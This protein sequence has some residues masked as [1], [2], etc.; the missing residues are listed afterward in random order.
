MRKTQPV[1]NILYSTLAGAFSLVLITGCSEQNFG[2]TPTTKDFAQSVKYNRQADVL[3][4]ME[5]SGAMDQQQR[6]KAVSDQV[7]AMM[8]VLNAANL[9]YH[10]AVTT[11]TPRF[12]DP[13]TQTMVGDGGRFITHGDSSPLVLS[14][15]LS[16]L[17][18]VLTN[19]LNF[20]SG[21]FISPINFG[22]L[23]VQ[24][25]LSA[26]LLDGFNAGFLR[27]DAL[28]N[29]IFI[30]SKD[31][32]VNNT[33]PIDLGGFLDKLR[34]PVAATGQ[35][36]WLAHYVGVLS[37]SP[38]DQC[39]S[40][41]WNY[42]SPGIKFLDIV[43]ASGGSSS[44]ICSTDLTLAVQQVQARILEI[45][46]AYHLNDKPNVSTIVVYAAGV[47]VPQ[48]AKNGWTYDDKI[49]SIV[50]HGLAIPPDGT[51]FHVDYTPAGIK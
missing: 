31:D 14:S 37:S 9:D 46:T 47:L 24:N 32:D 4:V 2:L 3:I 44:T 6:Y 20:N 21:D 40:G 42:K 50:F 41:Q 1:K 12:Q 15:S 38:S 7:P 11:M 30:S 5:A 33:S 26:P 22:R 29:I 51:P 16:N 45:V 27:A 34:P 17:T 23:A 25:A 13:Q 8:K 28:L 39:S 36:S 48:D 43:N 19:R 35:R 10:I 18:D 49:Q